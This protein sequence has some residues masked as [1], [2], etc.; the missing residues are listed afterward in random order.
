MTQGYGPE[1]YVMKKAPKG[2]YAIVV[3]Y[4]SANPNLLAG[5]THVN[6]IVTKWAG[7]PEEQVQRYT[8]ILKKHQEQVEVCRVKY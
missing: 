2:E 1:R 6:V 3:H 8:V 4:Y 7:T 5:E